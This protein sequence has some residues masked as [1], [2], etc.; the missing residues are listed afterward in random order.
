MGEPAGEE[1]SEEAPPTGAVCALLATR[2]HEG[3]AQPVHEEAQSTAPLQQEQVGHGVRA[4]SYLPT[5]HVVL[6]FL[7]A[8]MSS[9]CLT[10]V[11]FSRFH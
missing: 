3:P 9:R 8:L 11:C 2:L 5:V 6:A 10:C 7:S 4:D 1:D